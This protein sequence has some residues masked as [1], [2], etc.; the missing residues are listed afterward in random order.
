MKVLSKEEYLELKEYYP[1]DRSLIHYDN[2]INY[3][4]QEIPSNSCED[5][6]DMDDD[7][8]YRYCNLI[9]SL[10]DRKLIISYTYF[11]ENDEFEIETIYTGITYVGCLA[12]E[13]YESMQ[14]KEDLLSS[15]NE[16]N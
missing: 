8:Y 5:D 3:P 16:I 1:K 2:I 14:Q 10:E 12:V 6:D 11:S 13:I 15:I 9:S 7:E 4:F